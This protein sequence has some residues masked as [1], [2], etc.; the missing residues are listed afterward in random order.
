MKNIAVILC[1]S[2][3][4]D[5]SEIREAVGVLWALSQHAISVQC[6]APDAPQSDVVNCF[7][8]QTV[9]SESRNMLVES[10]RIAR[11]D[12]HPLQKL[13]PKLFDAVVMPG[14]FG[15]AKNLCTFAK[16]G[17]RGT[18]RPE[19]QKIL[20][21]MYSLKKPIGAVCIAPAIVA[22]ALKNKGIELTVGASSEAAQE[23]ERTGNRHQVCPPDNCHVDSVHKVVTTPA[24][25]YDDAKLHS[26][27]TG[28]QKMVEAI[29]QIA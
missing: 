20:E 23:I 13:D 26:I 2:G 6:F 18:V 11:G 25:M 9:T 17:A 8:G 1:G 15:A 12:I 16:E 10:A 28:I 29:L 27:F 22:L 14:G 24:Y 19:L 21:S 5:G 4:K 7:T 3:F